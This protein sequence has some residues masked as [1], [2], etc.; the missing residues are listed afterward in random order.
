[1]DGLF[2][3]FSE[4]VETDVS[5][6]VSRDEDRRENDGIRGSAYTN[7]EYIAL[8]GDD[9]TL[10][11][12]YDRPTILFSSLPAANFLPP[13]PANLPPTNEVNN[14]GMVK[15]MDML[16]PILGTFCLISSLRI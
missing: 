6:D 7:E 3:L 4:V 1:M 2:A 12:I 13:S 14:A 9:A 11:P 15:K 16:I 8:L 10:D 5:I